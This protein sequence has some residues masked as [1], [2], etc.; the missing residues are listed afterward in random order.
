MELLSPKEGDHINLTEFL[1]DYWK[2]SVD[3]R[4]EI[5]IEA[6]YRVGL[7]LADREP[8]CEILYRRNVITELAEFLIE[9]P[10]GMIIWPQLIRHMLINTLAGQLVEYPAADCVDRRED[11]DG[12]VLPGIMV[13]VLDPEPGIG[14]KRMR[15]KAYRLSL[16]NSA[17]GDDGDPGPSPRENIL[18]AESIS[19]SE[20]FR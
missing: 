8:N 9:M 19:T 11:L 20:L 4:G 16:V 18:I 14:R 7:W 12:P 2:L 1:K 10:T 3:D 17:P 5:E 15:V 6:V 13:T